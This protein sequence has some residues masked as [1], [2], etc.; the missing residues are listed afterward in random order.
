MTAIYRYSILA[1]AALLLASCAAGPPPV[2]VDYDPQAE[3]SGLRSYYLLDP[4]ATGAFSPLD[5]KRARNAADSLLGMRFERA[6]DAAS[7]DF[8]VRLQLVSEEKVAVYEDSF[9]LYGGYHSWGFGWRAP[10]QVRQY[11]R[12]ILVLDILSPDKSPLWR[13]SVPSGAGRHDDPVRRQ[14]RLREDLALLLNRFPPR[15]GAG[16]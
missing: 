13:A 5:L 10:L 2:A 4:L 11:R 15:S 8:L 9:G 7:A 6:K 14:Q 1:L 16:Y 3:F 12:D